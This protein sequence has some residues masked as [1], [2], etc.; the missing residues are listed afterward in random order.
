MHNVH[1]FKYM[2]IYMYLVI[3]LFFFFSKANAT[4]IRQILYQLDPTLLD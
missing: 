2:Y 3:I 4:V 1:T